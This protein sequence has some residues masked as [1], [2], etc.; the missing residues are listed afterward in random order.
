MHIIGQATPEQSVSVATPGGSQQPKSLAQNEDEAAASI[1][2]V[3]P[4]VSIGMPVF[5]N[6]KTLAT[7]VRSILNQTYRNWELLVMDDGSA[8]RTLEVARSFCDPRILVFTDHSHKGLVPRLNQAIELSRGKY[9]ARMDGDDVAYPERFERQTK[10][11]EEHPG[12]DLLGCGMLVFRGDG[13]AMGC[14]PVQKTHEEICRRPSDGFY[15]GH[16][17]WMGR[18]PWFRCHPYDAKAVRAEDQ[19]LLLRSYSSSRFA[20]LPEILCGYQE[21]RLVLRKILRSRYG[22]A[23]AVFR[24]FFE[25]EQYFTAVGGMLRQC[26]KASVDI[27]A[28][29]TGLNYLLVAHR[30]RSLNPASLQRWAKVWS[31][32]KD[33]DRLE[34]PARGLLDF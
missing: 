26:V 29:T 21:D 16:P 6:E 14:R 17:T 22:F 9:F 30:A 25:R 18:I 27:L 7:A 33:S 5:N 23:A 15:I 34:L 32:V 11:L 4:V 13:V 20:C 10:Y 19:V 8:D 31:Q 3:F 2:A 1:E 24:E 28:I 12:V